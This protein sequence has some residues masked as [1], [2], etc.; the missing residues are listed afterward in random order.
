MEKE[1]ENDHQEI[2]SYSGR[3]ENSEKTFQKGF[4]GTNLI[5]R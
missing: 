3:P 1:I 2:L 5:N 4:S